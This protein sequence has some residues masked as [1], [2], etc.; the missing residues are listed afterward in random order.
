MLSLGAYVVGRRDEGFYVEIKPLNDNAVP[1]ALKVTG[2]NLAELGRTGERPENALG[3]FRDW[4]FSGKGSGSFPWL[5][6][7][8]LTPFRFAFGLDREYSSFRDVKR[9]REKVRVPFVFEPP[10]GSTQRGA[11]ATVPRVRLCPPALPHLA[12]QDDAGG[13]AVVVPFSG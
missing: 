2:F 11:D 1:Q 4:V 7:M 8:N 10:T 9:T 13:S 3:K 6:K 5:R 12:R